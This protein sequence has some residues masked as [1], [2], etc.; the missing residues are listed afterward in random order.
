MV[1]RGG[2]GGDLARGAAAKWR[3]EK[4]GGKVRGKLG[5]RRGGEGK[6]WEREERRRRSNLSCEKL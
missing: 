3:R 4:G 2:G 5:E 6:E 1:S